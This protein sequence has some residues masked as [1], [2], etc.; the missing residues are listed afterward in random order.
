[1]LLA[2]AWIPTSLWGAT[3]EIGLYS[4]TAS[5]PLVLKRADRPW[6]HT[7]IEKPM[8]A[9]VFGRRLLASRCDLSR[10]LLMAHSDDVGLAPGI[11]GTE[12]RRARTD[13]LRTLRWRE[14]NSNFRFL[15]GSTPPRCAPR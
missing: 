9:V 8:S 4:A 2:S 1:M 6:A 14:M 7:V 3:R 12:T 5:A 13:G 11:S 10:L 15:G